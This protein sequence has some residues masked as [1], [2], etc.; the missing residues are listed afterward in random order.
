VKS[1]FYLILAIVLAYVLYSWGWDNAQRNIARQCVA[2]SHIFV[3][4][5]TR[6]ICGTPRALV[7]AASH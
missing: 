1:I 6:F 4:Q 2:D 7:N 3:Y 5:Q